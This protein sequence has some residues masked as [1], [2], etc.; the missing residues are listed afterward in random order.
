MELIARG[1]DA[2]GTEEGAKL[3]LGEATIGVHVEAH[4][5][6]VQLLELIGLQRS[7]GF[8]IREDPQGGVGR[9]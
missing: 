3:E 1:L 8:A 4:E 5:N 2:E 9:G 6:V 7:H